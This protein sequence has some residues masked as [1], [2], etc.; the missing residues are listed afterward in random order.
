M[1]NNYEPLTLDIQPP[2]IGSAVS[3]TVDIT[4]TTDDITVTITDVHGDHSYT[5]EKTDGAIAD[6][7]AATAAAN[8]AASYATSTADNAAAQ[9]VSIAN[10]AAAS[11]V[12]TATTAANNANAKAELADI[13]A[14][15]ANTKAALADS[16]ATLADTAATNAN[17]KATLA[18]TAAST[19]NTA[20]SN[21]D[22]KAT[23][24]QEAATAATGAASTANTAASNADAKAALANTAASNADTKA[25]LADT[26]ATNANTKAGLA[27]AAATTANTAAAAADA[28]REAIQDDLAAKADLDAYAPLLTSGIAESLLASDEQ[29]AT[30]T[31]RVSDHDGSVGVKALLGNTV[32]WNQLIKNNAA[33]AT[34]SGIT[35]TNNGNGS[36]TVSGTAEADVT[37]QLINPSTFNMVAGHKYFVKGCPA[38]GSSDSYSYYDQWYSQWNDYGNGAIFTCAS[39][40]LQTQ[41]TIKI[42][43]GT[44]VN[45]LVFHPQMFDLTAMFGAGNEPATVAEFERM[46]T[47][48]YYPYDAGSLLSVNIEGIESEGMVREIPVSTYFPDGLRGAGTAHDALYRDHADTVIGAVDLG[49]ISWYS[50]VDSGNT[51]YAIS[52]DLSGLIKSP[53]NTSTP[54]NVLS[55]NYDA[56]AWNIA[57]D[58][59]IY[60]Y[61]TGGV[62][63]LYMYD[64][65]LS[66]KS[67]AQVKE[68]FNGVVMFY[69]LATPTT[70]PIDQPINMDYITQAGGV[71][72]I[73]IP[74]G[75]QSAPVT[76]VYV[77]GYDADGVAD[78]ALS[79]VATLEGAKASTNYAIG[80]YFVHDGTLYR[81]T[82]AIATG[83]TITP[84][85][86]CTATTVMAEIIRLT[87]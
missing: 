48:S 59:A 11:A 53:D 73:V 43:N 66:G 26:A 67:A 78:K 1:P 14:T 27:D 81:A 8:A 34:G 63:R 65:N 38:G 56:K 23:A 31:Q 20:A 17:N 6:A 83:E 61:R 71:E 69:E 77:Q 3:P 29:Q 22:A 84:G 55:V 87:A 16:K 86:N 47:E 50:A 15:N 57:A 62:D 2:Y 60:V 30:F 4:E 9:A 36:W 28:A 76:M 85:T 40:L 10:T 37:K 41:P 18:N 42:A 74:E 52:Y 39:S 46:F 72:S 82:S 75:E 35:F 5:V 51:A 21:A 12:S 45:N 19:A 64:P 33:S 32:R 25:A 79:V 49:A 58:K 24:A 7:E 13:A 54:P 70:T 80:A 44:T 68:Y